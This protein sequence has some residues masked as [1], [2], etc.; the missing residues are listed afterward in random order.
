MTA[1]EETT[2]PSRLAPQQKRS[3]EARVRIL[4]AAESLLRSEGLDG[5][6]MAAVGKVAEMPVGNIYRRFEGRDDLLQA[7]KDVVALRI[8]EAVFRAVRDGHYSDLEAYVVA[9]SNAVGDVFSGDQELH[10]ALFDPRVASRRMLETGQSVRSTIFGLF[11][12][13]LRPY[14]A[15]LPEER[16]SS[17]ARVAFSIITNAAILKVRGHDPIMNAFSWLEVKAEY[18]AAACA[19][20]QLLPR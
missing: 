8:R 10:R 14:L 9:F 1:S 7:L 13:G 12:A 17:A 4:E 3:R 16:L 20:L 5:F 11:L 6:S 19:Y 18:G 2:A 15:N